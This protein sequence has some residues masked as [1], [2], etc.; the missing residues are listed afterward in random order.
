VRLVVV[1]RSVWEVLAIADSQGRSLVD[2]IAEIEPGDYRH[3]ESMLALIQHSVPM[4]GPPKKKLRCRDLGKDV[5][6][7]KHGPERGKKIRVLWFY[8]AGEPVARRR[9]ICTTW[10][11]KRDDTLAIERETTVRLRR[12][13]IAAKGRGALEFITRK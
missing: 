5:L 13:Y 6:E 1:G 8:D 2:E 9:I 11:F 12:E 10:S 3:A 7:F 4:N